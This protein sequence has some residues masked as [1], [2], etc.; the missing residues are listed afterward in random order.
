M[1]EYWEECESLDRA[2]IRSVAQRPEVRAFVSY[3]PKLI[4]M[5][6]HGQ[7]IVEGELADF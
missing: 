2:S 1:Q 3:K 6:L 5:S 7:D 4:R